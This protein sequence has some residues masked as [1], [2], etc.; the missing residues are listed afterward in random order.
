[1]PVHGLRCAA[2]VAAAGFG[3]ASALAED[4]PPLF[5][6]S[7]F[8]T[9]GVI[10]S[11]NDKADYLVDAFHPDGSAYTHRWSA[12]ADSRAALQLTANLTSTL[13]GVVQVIAEQRYDGT[14][15][16]SVEWAN[17]KLQV[18]PELSVRAGR[19]VLPVFSVTDSR[20]VGYANVWVRPPVEVY[21]LVPVTSN[22]GVDASYRMAIG[23]ATNSIQAAFGRSDSKFPGSAGLGAGTAKARNVMTLVDTFEKGFFTARVN[24]GQGRLSID[25][26]A[27]LGDALR[28]FGPQGAALADKYGVQDKRVDFVGIGAAYDPGHWFVTG[29][30]ANFNTRSI[31]GKKDAWYV[32]GGFRFGRATPYATYARLKADSNTSDPGLSL[33]GLPPQAAAAGAQLNAIMNAQLGAIPRQST[34]SAGVRWDFMSNF[35]LKLQYDRVSLG[36]TSYGTFGNVQPGFQAGGRVQLFS[37]TLDFVF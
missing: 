22:D 7:G 18:T 29:E 33:A 35:A 21:S 17:V 20:K 14:Y 26:Y 36:A 3:A 15:R 30:W 9:L 13:T 1:M 10:H 4:T 8:G 12:D 19:A 5:S 25:E 27:P 24:Y 32:S 34:I 23:E 16:P 6:F 31:I 2:L 28:A 11:D 37:A